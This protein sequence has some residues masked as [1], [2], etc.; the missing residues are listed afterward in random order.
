MSEP[1]NHA[2]GW[3]SNDRCTVACEEGNARSVRARH[4]MRGC[5]RRRDRDNA[6]AAPALKISPVLSTT[7]SPA[8]PTSP[9]ALRPNVHTRRPL[10]VTST[11]GPSSPWKTTVPC[12]VTDTPPSS[13]TSRSRRARRDATSQTRAAPRSPTA[14]TIV[15]RGS[16][17]ISRTG[18][19][20]SSTT[21]RFDASSAFLRASSVVG[22]GETRADSA[23]SRSPSSGSVGSTAADEASSRRACASRASSRARSRCAKAK[24]AIAASTRAAATTPAAIFVVRWRRRLSSSTARSASNRP[25]QPSTAPARTSWKISHRPTSSVRRMRCSPSVCRTGPTASSDT[26]ANPARSAA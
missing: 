18:S 4:D 21:R 25:V 7:R 14:A 24:T 1:E 16:S 5:P 13:P 26:R 17:E 9:T 19:P 15:P 12:P 10:G 2:T 11:G 23:A 20:R 3:K 6:P 8:N 22:P